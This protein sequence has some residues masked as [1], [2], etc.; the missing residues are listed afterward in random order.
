MVHFIARVGDLLARVQWFA[1]G[2]LLAAL[3]CVTVL[4]VV[5]RNTGIFILWVEDV[6]MLLLLWKVL[7]GSALAIRYGGHYTVDVFGTLPTGVERAL[8]MLSAVIVALVLSV[9]L[10]KGTELG[11]RLRFRLSGAAELPM[12]VY[13][14]AFPVAAVLG[15]FHLIEALLTR[16]RFPEGQGQP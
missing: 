3:S 16:P 9:L 8:R 7:L 4:Q 6:A 2:L 12:Y 1:I 14:A 15:A 5:S 10:W 11:W 13:Y